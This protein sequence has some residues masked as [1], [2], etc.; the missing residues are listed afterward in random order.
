MG[1]RHKANLVKACSALAEVRAQTNNKCV[2][3]NVM[4]M[5]SVLSDLFICQP[6]SKKSHKH[7]N[8]LTFRRLDHL[9]PKLAGTDS[10]DN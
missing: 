6:V 10:L 7:I 9:G 2:N 8:I 3:P 1:I 4:R 5:C